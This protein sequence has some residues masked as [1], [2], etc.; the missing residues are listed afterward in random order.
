MIKLS[1]ETTGILMITLC[2]LVLDLY[3]ISDHNY[4]DLVN[5]SIFT[6]VFI[7]MSI[8]LIRMNIKEHKRNKTNRNGFR[9]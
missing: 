1:D 6:I 5:F 4:G 9:N 2:C 3:L 7:V 8:L